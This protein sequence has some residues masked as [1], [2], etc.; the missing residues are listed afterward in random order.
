MLGPE[1]APPRFAAGDRVVVS[2]APAPPAAGHTR[3]PRYTWGKCGTVV[4]HR[5]AMVPPDRSAHGKRGA[6]ENFY[7]VELDGRELWGDDAEPGT[8]V[9]IDLLESYLE[10]TP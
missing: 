5:G 8:A 10:A 4:V 6:G 9:R 1:A 7:T 2:A 3:R